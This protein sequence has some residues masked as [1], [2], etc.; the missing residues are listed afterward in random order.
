MLCDNVNGDDRRVR[1]EIRAGLNVPGVTCFWNVNGYVRRLV[2]EGREDAHP[3]PMGGS[4]KN[5]LTRNDI[6]TDASVPRFLKKNNVSGNRGR[7]GYI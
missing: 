4:A 6:Y 3:I 1:E 2:V 7:G 5:V